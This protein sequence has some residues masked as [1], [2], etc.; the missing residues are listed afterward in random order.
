METITLPA[1]HR[2]TT[3]YRV[4]TLRREGLIPGVIYGHRVDP[5]NIQVRRS[6]LLR[7][8]AKAGRT[9]LVTVEFDDGDKRRVLLRELQMDPR[10]HAPSHVDFYQVN[11]REKVSADVPV[12][13]IGEA[14]AVKS[15]F[16]DLVQALQRIRV[17]ALPDHIPASIEVD[18]ST[19]DAADSLIRF[20][21]LALPADVECQVDPE[22]VVARITAHRVAEVEEMAEAAEG[23][24]AAP[25]AEAETGEAG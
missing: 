11:L 7:V 16:G 10:R 21:D 24:E 2:E 8:I 17:S 3:G 22:E 20:Q 12:V 5:L 23:A 18:V 4:A 9:Q 25:A 15:R 1:S 19:L 6:D 13:L 14:P